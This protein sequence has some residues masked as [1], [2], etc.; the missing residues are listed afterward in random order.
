VGAIAY[1]PEFATAS[2]DTIT[3]LG[4]SKVMTI[5]STYDHRV[6]QGA[7]SGSF[8]RTVE[9]LLAGGEAFYEGIFGAFGLQWAAGK[10]GSRDGATSIVELPPALPPSR[11]SATVDDLATVA[12]AMALVKAYRTHGHLAARL[13]PLGSEPSGDPALDPIGL[14]LTPGSRSPARPS[15]TRI[16]I[17]RRP[18]AEPSPT[19]SSTSA[20][21]GSGCGCAR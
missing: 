19:K 1:P 9:Q 15:P 21:T 3:R 2:P 4:L 16:P 13:D 8:L 18:T 10:A 11:P 5:T 14:G 7:E 20:T 17:S 12:A 6:I